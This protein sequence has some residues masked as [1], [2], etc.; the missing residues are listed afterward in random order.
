MHRK[1]RMY[2]FMAF[3][4]A[5]AL[6][7]FLAMRHKSTSQARPPQ[8]PH[9]VPPQK[10][11]HEPPYKTRVPEKYYL[12]ANTS[13]RASAVIVILARNRDLR[14]VVSSITQFEAKFNHKFGYPYVFLN[15]VPF[16]EEFKKEVSA[17]TTASVKFGLIPH[18]HW[19]QPD[20]IDEARASAVRHRMGPI[21]Y[22]DS[23][24]YRNMCRFQSGFFF[25]HEL[26]EPFKYYWRVEPDVQF[27]CDID[28]DPFLFM[29]GEDKKYAFTITFPEFKRVIKGLWPAV[30]Y[31][32]AANPDLITPDNAMGML[33]DRTG[34]YWNRC[35]F[36]SNFEI[37]A[38]DLWRSD[39]YLKFFEFLDARGGFYYSRWGDAPIHTF[40]AALFARKDQIH[41]F[42]EIGY[43][44]PF[45]GHCPAE[46]L[47]SRGR[48]ECNVTESFDTHPWSCLDKY[49]A[50]FSPDGPWGLNSNTSQRLE[51]AATSQ[52][53]V[54]PA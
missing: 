3:A 4:V 51:R 9:R 1:R 14:G 6:Y 23:V 37:A 45:F 33:A 36:W 19:F 12:M 22:G 20:W 34:T 8:P 24:S 38:F 49:D 15:E 46:P 52:A 31:F 26:L 43:L 35:H 44:H 42:N 2:I 30:K 27:Y 16:T 54:S 40:G 25:R 18:E 47:H 50:L 13:Q 29:E 7:Y 5:L 11:W 21:L 32:I 53:G 39:A 10:N 28:F 41:F 17:L 48:C